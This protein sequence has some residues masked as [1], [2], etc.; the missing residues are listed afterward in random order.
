MKNYREHNHNGDG[1]YVKNYRKHRSNG[2]GQNQEVDNSGGGGG[3]GGDWAADAGIG[4]SG[5]ED[6]EEGG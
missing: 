5:E 3:G 2:G 1:T 4:F 6:A